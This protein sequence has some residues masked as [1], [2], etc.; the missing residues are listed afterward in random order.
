M[1]KR[2][3]K[4]Y[5]PRSSFNNRH[6]NLAQCRNGKGDGNIIRIN[7][8]MHEAYHFLFGVM[9][10]KEVANILIEIERMM[11]ANPTRRYNFDHF[12]ALKNSPRSLN[13]KAGGKH[14]LQNLQIQKKGYH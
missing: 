8:Q 12:F 5:A 14:D 2:K 6:H 4:K 9:T 11:K 1:R 10:F 7:I 3:R 13:E